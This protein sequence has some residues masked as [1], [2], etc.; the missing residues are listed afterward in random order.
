[1][2]TIK[3]I[4]GRE[5]LDS[6]GWPTLECWLEL[7]DGQVV[8][9]SVPAGASTGK[10][11]ALELRDQGERYHGKGVLKAIHNLEK[12]IAPLFVG[13][14]PD[15][16]A[17]DQLMIEADGTERKSNFGANAMLAASIAIVSAQALEQGLE[18]FE[19][20]A[21]LC[22]RPPH[23]PRC[24]FNILNGGMHGDSGTKFQ[25]FMIMPCKQNPFEVLLEEAVLV[26]Q[27]LKVILKKRSYA[28]GIGD[29]GGFAPQLPGTGVARERIALDLLMEA[30]IQAGFNFD[31][32]K[33]CLDVAA[34]YFF[35]EQKKL[36]MI[37]DEHFSSQ[38]LVD[39]Y[40]D[41]VSNYPIYSIEDGMSQDD[42]NGWQLLTKR[43]G[44]KIQL[45]GDD[46][47]VTNKQFIERGFA[48]GVAN[49]VLIKPN[50]IGTVTEALNALEYARSAGY[51]I[52]ASHRSGETI[53]SFIAD[54]AVGAGA[55]QFKAGA[56]AR[57]ERVVK[58]NRILEIERVLNP[59]DY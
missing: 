19:L 45:V 43:L 57:G 1:M 6:R 32:F 53:D 25:E 21:R 38:D 59:I 51:S 22:N 39:L 35:D 8:T 20:I 5:I 54:L 34:S 40:E 37:D 30:I 27:Q 7:S 55:D 10:Y 28:T 46:I 24:M 49:A 33:I 11:E 16:F 15:L 58:Y 17:L 13:K 29:E 50:Q 12:S 42:W 9:A 31:Q 2:E 3:R 41:L 14:T 4:R 56:C 36:Y 52:V 44:D 26:Y 48:H 23:I 18:A 47:F